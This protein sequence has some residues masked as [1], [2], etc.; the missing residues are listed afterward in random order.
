VAMRTDCLC[1]L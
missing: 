1:F